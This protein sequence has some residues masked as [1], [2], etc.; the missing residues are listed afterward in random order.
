MAFWVRLL[1]PSHHFTHE[2]G[3]VSKEET[4]AFLQEARI[5]DGTGQ[6]EEAQKPTENKAMRGTQVSLNSDPRRPGSPAEGSGTGGHL[7][8]HCVAKADPGSVH[9]LFAWPLSP[10]VPC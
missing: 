8:G 9:Y 7:G 10:V 5:W 4:E 6:K 3:S 1:S 2:E